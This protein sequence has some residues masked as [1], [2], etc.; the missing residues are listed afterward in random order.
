MPDSSARWGI[1]LHILRAALCLGLLLGAWAGT[2]LAEPPRRSP[3]PKLWLPPLGAGVDPMLIGGPVSDGGWLVVEFDAK[4]PDAERRALLA[5]VGASVAQAI[6]DDA[7][8][9]RAPAAAA[10]LL[11][12]D[13]RVITITR[14]HPAYKLAPP[15]AAGVRGEEGSTRLRLL[16]APGAG[17][18]GALARVE[19][20]GAE[21]SEVWE[22]AMI[23]TAPDEAAIERLARL[24]DVL[25]IE[26]A[27]EARLYND[28]SRGICQTSELTNYRVHQHGVRGQGEIVAV[29]DS[30]IDTQHC[31][32]DAPSKIID[33]RAWGGGKLGAL[34]GND[35]GTHVSGTTACNNAGNH[36]GL[37][38]DAQLIMQ[39]IQSDGFF[40]CSVGSVSPPSDLAAAWQDAYD[41]GACVHTNSWGGGG[42]YYSGDSRAMDQFMWEH[43]DFL[44]LYAAGNSGSSSGSLGVYSNAKNSITVGGTVN[45]SSYEN[46]YS[47]SSRGPAGDGRMLPD[48]LTPAQG[49]SSS[50]NRTY[51]SCGWFTA[52]GTSMAAPAAAGSAA[53]VRDY[54]ESGFYPGGVSSAVDGFSPTAA[55]VK[56]TML[57]STRNMTGSG[58]RGDRPNSDQGFGRVTLDDALWFAD[59][60]PA[61]QLR[62]L[63]DRDSATGLSL[64]G[65]EQVFEVGLRSGAP[66]KVMLVWTDAPGSPSASKE[67]INDLDLVVTTADGKT[68]RGNQGFSGGWTESVSDQADRLNNKEAVF[69][70]APYPGPVTVSVRAESLGDVALHP[71]DYALVVVGD[72]P[73]ECSDTGGATGVGDSVLEDRSGSD[74]KSSWS[75]GGA[76]SYVVYRGTS[77]DF[78]SQGPDPYRNDVTDEDPG[79]AGVQWTD[80]G[81]AGDS[82]NYYYLYF[83]KNGCDELLP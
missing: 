80:A 5:R 9:V 66:L 25:F 22:S 62:I 70:V 51:A 17:K 35:H 55:L 14:F 53:L 29:M 63:D 30:G 58:T 3:G 71:Q 38:P 33:N 57:V 72:T 46:M 18:A 34:C 24:D 56:A 16:L 54:Y 67:L 52:S 76:A 31:C 44:I 75:D 60:P 13:P 1:C 43:Q 82:E 50:R 19:A 49:V 20:T 64:A 42:N 73:A 61:E 47:A 41:R 32:F 2:L 78:M 10:G 45:G 48:L 40:A 21:V 23:V 27:V 36:D 15:L 65:E 26:P 74:V 6:P 12:A 77:P 81:A 83:A 8:L 68:Y 11:G 37:A 59:D 39:D 4:V 28:S 7:L 69:L 79:Q